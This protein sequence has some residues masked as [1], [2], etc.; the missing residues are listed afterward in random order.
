MVK[1]NTDQSLQN[2][3]I[4]YQNANTNTNPNFEF[5]LGSLVGTLDK[6]KTFFPIGNHLEMMILDAGGDLSLAFWGCDQNTTMGPV[7]VTVEVEKQKAS[8]QIKAPAEINYD[9]FQDR[10][11]FAVYAYANSVYRFLTN[12]YVPEALLDTDIKLQPGDLLTIES[13]P[14]DLWSPDTANF[15]NATGRKEDDSKPYGYQAYKSHNY[16]L[17]SLIGSLDGGKTFFPVGTHL[18]MTVLNEGQLS[19]CFW[20]CD[21]GN[22]VGS[23]TA[24]VKVVRSGKNITKLTIATGSSSDYSS[25]VISTGNASSGDYASLDCSTNLPQLSTKLKSQMIASN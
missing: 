3:D 17:G 18:E 13:H 4:I 2:F 1:I 24:F 23:V 20:D 12:S 5:P 25:G 22:N 19:F 9:L 7:T 14:R 8:A 16:R 10:L 15:V 11:P 6:G 21:Y